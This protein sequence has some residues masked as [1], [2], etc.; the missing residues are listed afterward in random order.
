MSYRDVHLD[1]SI[2]KKNRIPLLIRD[3]S[4]LKLFGKSNNKVIENL[5]DELTHLINK[6]K[7][8]E[9]K[10][11]QLKEEKMLAMKMILGIS[12]SVNNENKIQNLDLLDEY[13]EKFEDINRQLEEITEEIERISDE[14]KELNFYLLKATVYYGYK[15]LKKKERQL[16]DINDE[17]DKM[18]KRI[19]E[20]IN[21][22][23]NYQEW[24]QSVYTF[25]H[26]LLGREEIEKLDEKIFE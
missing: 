12:N 4:W 8:L 23:H 26:G 11:K 20:L 15:D 21:E 14:I 5:K 13:K 1:E 25:L 19:K 17:L 22:K 6:R 7:A 2:I 3:K 10:E 18:R 24:I 16:K 9:R